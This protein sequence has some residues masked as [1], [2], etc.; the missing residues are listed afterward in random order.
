MEKE[1]NQ[2][3]SFLDLKILRSSSNKKLSFLVYRKPSFT[4]NYLRYDS[5]NPASHKRAVAK[6]LS[7]RA[8]RLCDQEYLNEEIKT[9]RSDLAKNGYP[10]SFVS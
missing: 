10:Q 2:Q 1:N 5:N 7:D 3:I 6:S 4:G 9:I 8:K